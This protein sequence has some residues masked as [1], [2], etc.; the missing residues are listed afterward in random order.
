MSAAIWSS[1]QQDILAYP[2]DAFIRFFDNH[3]LLNL[4][5]RPQW[6]TVT[7]GSRKYVE[8][9]LADAEVEERIATPVVKIERQRHCNVVTL[10][11][12]ARLEFDEVVLAT[13]AD[14][15][16]AL[17]AEPSQDEQDILGAFRYSD[18]EAWLHRDQRFM[19]TRKLA[20]ASW[21][22]LTHVD[23]DINRP[24]S[25]TYW[26][27]QLQPLETRD[28]IF[29]TLNPNE[30]PAREKVFGRYQYTHPIF[31][32]RTALAQE[33]S[34]SIQGRHHTWFCGAYLG[35]GFHEDAAQSGFWIAEALGAERPWE[36]NGFDRLPISYSQLYAIAA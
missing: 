8:A 34:L 32:A 10:S 24:L 35:A 36:R 15:A 28:D 19:P 26:M 16:L 23:W 12:G 1:S 4:S 11:D 9:L 29:V 13:H 14:E 5:E 6:K 33:R 3:G 18:N 30:P 7:G 21:N 27:N 2:A 22:Y 25:V 31:T 20:W 17:I